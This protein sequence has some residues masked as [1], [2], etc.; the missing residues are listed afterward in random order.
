VTGLRE[1]GPAEKA[2]LKKGDVIVEYAGEP[3]DGIAQISWISGLQ[4][5][6]EPVEAVVQRGG[7]RK[8]F[9]LVPTQSSR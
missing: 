2:G 6:G 9:E 4:L 7:S 8:T 5:A 1:G 3:V